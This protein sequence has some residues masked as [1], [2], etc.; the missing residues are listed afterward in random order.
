MKRLFLLMLC[1]L[2]LVFLTGCLDE[3][4]RSAVDASIAQHNA[5]IAKAE[6]AGEPTAELV[7]LRDNLQIVADNDTSDADML[8]WL[9]G[10]FGVNAAAA[11]E[12]IRR[13]L[14]H[15]KYV[16]QIVSAFQGAEIQSENGNMTF[17]KER[18]KSKIP[19]ELRGLISHLKARNTA[20]SAAEQPLND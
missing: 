19:P 20:E 14:K 15:R 1:M 3:E 2:P 16:Y 18:V 6:A 11:V 7:V 5:D 17:D 12:A 9:L 4:E 8:R 10:L 13:Y